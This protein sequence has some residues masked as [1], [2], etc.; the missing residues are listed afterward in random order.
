MNTETLQAIL[1]EVHAA[2]MRLDSMHNQAMNLA[3]LD[4]DD[5]KHV[6]EVLNRIAALTKT[7]AVAYR[8]A[9]R[10]NPLLIRT[11]YVLH[12]PMRVR[13]WYCASEPGTHGKRQP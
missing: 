10:L 12:G 6:H 3:I 7:L 9:V 5:L 11:S 1:D 8:L 4:P 13:R 2:Q